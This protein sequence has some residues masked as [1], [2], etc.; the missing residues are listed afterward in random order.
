MKME[1][2]FRGKKKIKEWVEGLERNAKAVGLACYAPLLCNVDYVNWKPDMIWFDNHRVYGTPN[3]YVQKLFMENQ[4]DYLLDLK[5]EDVPE[6]KVISKHKDKITGEVV[7]SSNDTKVEYYD[8]TLVND[9]TKEIL[10]FDGCNLDREVTDYLLT[11]VD[12]I[13]YTVKLKAKE[14]EGFKGFK[15]QFGKTDDKNRLFL[16]LGGWQ[17]QDAVLCEDVNGRNSCLSQYLFTVEKEKEYEI[18]IQIKGRNI[19][20]FIN[21]EAYHTIECKPVIIEPLYYTASKEESTGDIILK[22]VNVSN[23][24]QKVTLELANGK[25]S[26]GKIYGLSGYS[27]EEV[28]DFEH[29]EFIFPSENEFVVKDQCMELDF[30]K[31]SIT[32]LRF[33]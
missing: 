16:E 17:N 8:I 2:L 6:S 30:P 21:G 28:N 12:W 22:V 13:N 27:M 29:P 24:D 18:E 9:D 7:L 3:Y 23:Q 31:E 26:K 10:T 14:L 32:I 25:V 33:Q 20:T 4:G 1:V 5:A 15:I 11:Q 19:A